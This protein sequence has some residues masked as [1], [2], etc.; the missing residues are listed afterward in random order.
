MPIETTPVPGSS[1]LDSSTSTRGPA[2]VAILDEL[3]AIPDADVLTPRVDVPAAVL[4][5]IGAAP[6]IELHRAAIAARF[7]EAGVRSIDRL[8]PLASALSVAQ[9]EH[10]ASPDVG[11]EA[12]AQ[13]LG[14]ERA[15]LATDAEVLVLRKVLHPRA[16]AGLIGGQAYKDRITDVDTLVQ[17]F[18]VHWSTVA[19]HTKL[20]RADLDH[21]DAMMIEFRRLLG[22]RDQM[23]G[24]ALTTSDVRAR[25]FTVF[26]RTYDHVRKMLGFLR[27]HE[28]DADQIAPSLYAGRGRSHD[29]A[30]G[31]GTPGN[32]APATNG[33]S[34]LPG[35]HPFIT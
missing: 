31:N 4:T 20:T 1:T 24:R 13:E 34:G 7:G 6:K 2:L 10:A 15:R 26:F 18:R 19:S 21:A 16:L 33:S 5:V 22:E 32:P 8:V 30:T 28:E 23:S 12:L 17:L 14:E 11:L 35:D 3:R 25:A 9:G 27:W 29:D